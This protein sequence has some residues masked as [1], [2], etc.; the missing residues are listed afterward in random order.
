[1]S[2]FIK[3]YDAHLKDLKLALET[4]TYSTWFKNRLLS[5]FEDLSAI[6]TTVGI[7]Y[8]DDGY[9][10]AK[11]SSILRGYVWHNDHWI[12]FRVDGFSLELM[13]AWIA[14]PGIAFCAFCVSFFHKLLILRFVLGF[15][16]TNGW[17]F[18]C[19]WWFS[20]FH[21][22][23]ILRISRI[24]GNKSAQ[25]PRKNWSMGILIYVRCLSASRFDRH[26]IK[27]VFTE[28]HTLRLNHY[29]GKKQ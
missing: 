21:V 23:L 8:D 27:L 24:P 18:L 14:F 20:R 2:D 29:F 26:C 11:A 3:L 6:T 4:R 25:D 16:F 12:N 22:N 7:N 1:M 5:Q 17:S 15:A 19:N 10:L 9:I 28:R 13:F